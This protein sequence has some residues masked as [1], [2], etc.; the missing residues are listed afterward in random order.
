LLDA[1]RIASPTERTFRQ[2]QLDAAVQFC[3]KV[4][5]QEYASLLVKAAGVATPQDQ[6]PKVANRA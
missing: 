1:L 6:A 3:A 4:F 5:G 2:S